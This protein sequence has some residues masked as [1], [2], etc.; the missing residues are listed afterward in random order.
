MHASCLS[1]FFDDIV[2]KLDSQIHLDEMEVVQSVLLSGE[3]DFVL[4]LIERKTAMMVF[5]VQ[6]LNKQRKA[7]YEAHKA[8]SRI[9]PEEIF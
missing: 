8:A 2:R 5:V 7:E 9:D 1:T 3:D 6:N 4:N